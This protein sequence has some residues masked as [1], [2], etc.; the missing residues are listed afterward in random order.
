MKYKKNGNNSWIIEV[1]ENG[2][3]KE[4]LVKFPT[5]CLDQVGWDTGDD[6]IWE[7]LDHNDWSIKRNETKQKL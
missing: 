5:G 3:T 4:L 7:E 1:Y 6:L 2:K